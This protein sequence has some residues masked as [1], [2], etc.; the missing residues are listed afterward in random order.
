MLPIVAFKK[1]T[2]LKQIIGTTTIHNNEKLVKTKSN[3]HTGKWV[4]CNS[5]LCLCCQQLISTAIFKSNQTSKTFKICHR[6]NCKSSFVIYLLECYICNIQYVG[7]SETPFNIR[8][9]NHRKDVKNPNAIPAC[10]HFNRHDHDFNNHGKIIIIEQ[11]RN[12]R[13]T[14]TET[15]KER[16]KQRENFW[17]MKLETLAPLGLNQD[18][19]WIHFMQTFRSPPLFFVS[20][21]GLK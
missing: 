18:L 13:T 20:A 3:H 15:L 14:S 10:K 11:L 6:V 2:S 21:Y 9:N 5:T 7:K 12:I 19:N 17:I 4:S 16:L 1:G 8:L